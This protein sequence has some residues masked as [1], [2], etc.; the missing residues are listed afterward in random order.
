MLVIPV[1]EGESIEK[2]LRKYKRKFDKVKTIKDLRRRQ[3][4]TKPS[5]SDREV[6]KKGAYKE[7]NRQ[8]AIDE[9]SDLLKSKKICNCFVE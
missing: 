8:R 1:K 7:S 5:I 4:Y 2:A 6:A 9:Q 3:N